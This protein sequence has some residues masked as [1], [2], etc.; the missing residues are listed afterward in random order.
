MELGIHN[1]RN[2]TVIPIVWAMLH[3]A[4]RL[5]VILCTECCN[6]V[7]VIMIVISAPGSIPHLYT[8]HTVC[9]NRATHNPSLGIP[10]HTVTRTS[11]P[12]PTVYSHCTM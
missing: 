12:V 2:V 10:V 11:F 5:P 4:V 1:M 8:T 9:L 3:P 6:A 7:Q